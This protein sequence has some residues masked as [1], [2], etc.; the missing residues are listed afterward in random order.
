MFIMLSSYSRTV[1]P[2]VSYR[3]QTLVESSPSTCHGSVA[4]PGA[5]AIPHPVHFIL[6]LVMHMVQTIAALWLVATCNC[7]V[8]TRNARV[9]F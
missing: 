3:V 6:T 7:E 9:R 5:H 2:I 4:R 8:A 1:A